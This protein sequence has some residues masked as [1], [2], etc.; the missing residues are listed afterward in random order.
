[1]IFVKIRALKAMFYLRVVNEVSPLI[2]YFRPI[3]T[4]L[5]QDLHMTPLRNSEFHENRC[6][7][8]HTLRGVVN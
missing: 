5:E 4:N 8:S 7:K 3:C 6:R 2:S 1:M